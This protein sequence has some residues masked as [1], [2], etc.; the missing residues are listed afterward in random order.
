MGFVS[1]DSLF[2]AGLNLF[3]S[4]PKDTIVFG[5]ARW[6]DLEFLYCFDVIEIPG[7]LKRIAVALTILGIRNVPASDEEKTDN[8]V[9]PDKPEERKLTSAPTK[10]F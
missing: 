2:N 10:G 1:F 6:F 8:T 9:V 7:S 3:F 5:Q 4:F